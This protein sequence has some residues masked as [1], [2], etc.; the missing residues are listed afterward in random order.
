DV[1]SEFL[2]HFDETDE[3]FLSEIA[4]WIKF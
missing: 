2:N 1:D 3:K 4:G